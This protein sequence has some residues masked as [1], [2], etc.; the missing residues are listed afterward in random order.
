[1]DLRSEVEGV[2]IIAKREA[3]YH[4]KS[5]RMIIFGG[6]LIAGMIL[7]SRSMSIQPGMFLT[8]E[9][10]YYTPDAAL[11][12]S[13]FLFGFFASFFA[14]LITYDDFSREKTANTLQFLLMKPLHY[15]S[16]VMGKFLG[17]FF[18]MC[19]PVIMVT[20]GSVAVISM[21]SGQNPTASGTLGFL[22]CLMLSIGICILFQQS[23]SI[24]FRTSTTSVIVGIT[25]LG[26]FSLFWQPFIVYMGVEVGALDNMWAFTMSEQGEAFLEQAALLNPFPALGLSTFSNSMAVF[27]SDESFVSIP[28]WLPP[29][30]LFLWFVLF[31][32]LSTFL[33]NRISRKI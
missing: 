22:L 16:I 26:F 6:I 7:M 12:A 32:L 2:F 24:V 4:L 1:M 25:V 33:F 31:L 13:T 10:I 20:L 17:A 21:S 30:V 3:L 23:L 14:L 15:T 27:L 19:V 11:F 18:A 8:G 9:E 5:L 29:V 28:R